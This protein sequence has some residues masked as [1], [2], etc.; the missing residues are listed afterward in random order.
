MTQ[1]E[2]E[3][4]LQVT[5]ILKMTN[6]AIVFEKA[7][8]PALLTTHESALLDTLMHIK[9]RCILC[10]GSPEFEPSERP[11]ADLLTFR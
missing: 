9:T 6:A 8:P 3:F 11:S 4:A 5:E 7:R 1:M 2:K 10:F